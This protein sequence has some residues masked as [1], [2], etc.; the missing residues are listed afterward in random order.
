MPFLGIALAAL[1][2][3]ALLWLESYRQDREAWSR[4]GFVHLDD[5]LVIEEVGRG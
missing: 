2:V 1:S 5:W 3:P 4:T